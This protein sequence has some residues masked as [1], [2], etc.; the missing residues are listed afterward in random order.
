MTNWDQSYCPTCGAGQVPDAYFCGNCG[1]SFQP[2]ADPYPHA[3]PYAEHQ[4]QASEPTYVYD[5]AGSYGHYED[6]DQGHPP[7]M[8][9]PVGGSEPDLADETGRSGR[10]NDQKPAGKSTPL[11]VFTGVLILAVTAA[12]PALLA[13]DDDSDATDEEDEA[14]PASVVN[15]AELTDDQVLLQTAD[16]VPEGAFFPDIALDIAQSEEAETDLEDIVLRVVSLPESSTTREETAA[17]LS[18]LA[19]TGTDAG[20]YSGQRQTEVCDRTALASALEEEGGD[21][22]IDGFAEALGLASADEVEGYV[23]DLTAVRLRHDTRVTHHSVVDG[24]LEPI[25]VVLQAG[26]GVLVDEVGLPRVSCNGGNP[27]GAPTPLEGAPAAE[28]EEEGTEVETVAANPADAWDRLDPARVVT[29]EAASD[30][31]DD[32]LF[33]DMDSTEVIERPAGTNGGRDMGPG[34]LIATLEWDSPA[35]LDLSVVDTNRATI[36][37]ERPDPEDSNGRLAEDANRLCEDNLTGQEQISWPDGDAP[38]G[39]Y[40]VQVTGHAVG[41]APANADEDTAYA[42]DCG[43]ESAEFKLSIRL[44]G[45]DTVVHEE[46]VTDGESKDYSVTLGDPADE[47]TDDS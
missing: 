13:T 22:P 18:E 43:G 1:T 20:V 15:I 36:S 10:P 11:L 26:T 39:E 7:L 5:Q 17:S 42:A 3:D 8:P 19:V 25:Q 35:D 12:S 16:E 28:D 44:Y 40:S 34:D 29:V 23:D 30:P 38:E 31:L 24:S 9:E 41:E 45:Q 33:V 2:A 37:G 4:A 47:E 21:A 46:S 27:L 14:A 32:L 6:P